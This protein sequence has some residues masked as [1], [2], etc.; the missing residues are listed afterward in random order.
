M[1]RR[2]YWQERS[3]LETALPALLGNQGAVVTNDVLKDEAWVG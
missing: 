2:P 3:L 1:E